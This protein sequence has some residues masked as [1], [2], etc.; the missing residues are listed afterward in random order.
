MYDYAGKREMQEMVECHRLHLSRPET[1][2][3]LDVVYQATTAEIKRV[4]DSNYT[5][6]FD[7]GAIDQAVRDASPGE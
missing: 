3:R 2:R 6:S 5:K 7:P 1:R 4:T